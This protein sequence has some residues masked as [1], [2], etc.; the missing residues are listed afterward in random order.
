MSFKAHG[1][2]RSSHLADIISVLPPLLNVLAASQQFEKLLILMEEFCDCAGR[3]ASN[4]VC[5]TSVDLDGGEVA[6]LCRLQRHK[7]TCRA[8]FNARPA[9]RRYHE[10]RQL[11]VCEALLIPAVLVRRHEYRASRSFCFR[12]QLAVLK[13]TPVHL[14]RRLD[15]PT[16]EELA[17]GNRH[18]LVEQ[19]LHSLADRLKSTAVKFYC[20]GN[21]FSVREPRRKDDL[22]AALDILAAMPD[23]MIETI[24]D[25]RPP[26]TRKEL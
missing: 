14:E 7:N 6:G 4:G 2:G 23:D 1:P 24:A 18:A 3:R 9:C 8:P 26:Q 25:R 5:A 20:S 17:Q 19:D 15:V 13:R 11:P 10:D 16:D 21:Q 12:Q 22:L